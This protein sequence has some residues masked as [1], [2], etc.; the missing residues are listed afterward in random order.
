MAL[1]GTNECDC[2]GSAVC[3]CVCAPIEIENICGKYFYVCEDNHHITSLNNG[4]D[5]FR[6][7]E[8]CNS[9]I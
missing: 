4:S 9:L 7:F 3:A 5:S 6:M 1:S 2:T 8:L